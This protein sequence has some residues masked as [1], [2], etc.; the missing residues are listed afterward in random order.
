MIIID[1]FVARWSFGILL[2]EIVTL[3]GQPYPG[4]NAEYLLEWLKLGK[5]NEKPPHCHPSLFKVMKSCWKEGP[6]DRPSFEE[7]SITLNNLMKQETLDDEQFIDLHKFFV[8][9]SSDM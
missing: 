7:L 1:Y 4:I 9:S 6:S 2:Y 8:K 5:R 3:G